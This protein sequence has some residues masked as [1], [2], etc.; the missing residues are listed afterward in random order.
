MVV[1][2]ALFDWLLIV[3]LNLCWQLKKRADFKANPA[4][5][6]P[7]VYAYMNLTSLK[8]ALLFCILIGQQLTK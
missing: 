4:H 5:V 8:T 7:F 2:L 6:T 1:Q 3:C